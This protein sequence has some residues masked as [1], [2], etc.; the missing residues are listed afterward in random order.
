[1]HGRATFKG[2]NKYGT[3]FASQSPRP[4]TRW[5]NRGHLEYGISIHGRLEDGRYRISFFSL[6][7]EIKAISPSIQHGEGPFWDV[8]NNELCYVDTFTAT[9]YRWSYDTNTITSLRLDKRDSVGVII[10]V[11]DK[12]NEF[13]VGADRHI[14][15]IIWKNDTNNEIQLKMLLMMEPSKPHNQFNDGKVDGKGRLWIGTLTRNEDLSVES[16][17]GSLYM[18]TGNDSL[19][20][21]EKITHTSISNGLAWSGDSKFMYYIDS[22]KRTVISYA[23]D[24]TEGNLGKYK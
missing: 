12:P 10:G 1:M 4:P 20:F 22:K 8:E 11:K 7:P 21:Y 24:E 13:I 3:C 15:K 2:L 9:I 19:H 6:S 5:P 23:F 14:Y 17:G 18:I 16:N